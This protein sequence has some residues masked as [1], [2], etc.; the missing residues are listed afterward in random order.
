MTD[1]LETQPPNDESENEKILQVYFSPHLS[2]SCLAPFTPS[3]EE[4]AVLRRLFTI[5]M[6][7]E[8]VV[9]YYVV[10]MLFGW[11]VCN[12]C[13][14]TVNKI[15]LFKTLLWFICNSKSFMG[16]FY[17]FIE[18]TKDKWLFFRFFVE[19]F[20][21]H[22]I[23]WTLKDH[24]ENEGSSKRRR[25]HSNREDDDGKFIDMKCF[26]WHQNKK[27]DDEWIQ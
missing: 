6:C 2:A 12:C 22:S 20:R 9:K 7:S 1:P 24:H 15:V 19:Y 13:A 8:L 25:Y 11:R 26:I 21:D 23:D 27:W 18:L 5:H 16:S 3:N 4:H 14:V 17:E 10:L